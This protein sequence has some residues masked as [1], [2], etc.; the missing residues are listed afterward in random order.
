MDSNKEITAVFEWPDFVLTTK[1][2]RDARAYI[3]VDPYVPNFAYPAGTELTLSA[4]PSDWHS[5]K[6]WKLYDPNHS[7]DANYVVIDDVNNPIVV[8]MNAD[9]EV[10][11]VF[12]CGSSV[13]PLLPVMLALGGLA[14]LRRRRG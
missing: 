5:F 14:L 6:Y 12:E 9:R 7:G 2:I 4:I 3:D 11:A 10:K 13:E 1:V 8:V